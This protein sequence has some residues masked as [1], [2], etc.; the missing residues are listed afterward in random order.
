V[1]APKT[2][3]KNWLSLDVGAMV[4]S[5]DFQRIRDQRPDGFRTDTTL[6]HSRG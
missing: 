5:S 3:H 1:P 2:L 6:E 4:Q